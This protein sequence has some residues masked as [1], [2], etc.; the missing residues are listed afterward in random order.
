MS[1]ISQQTLGVEKK[2]SGCTVFKW[3]WFNIIS[4]VYQLNY[5]YASLRSL[6]FPCVSPGR[7]L[8]TKSM[9]TLC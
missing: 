1:A 4:N 9:S 6:S 3:L 5:A 2:R 7:A 8:T